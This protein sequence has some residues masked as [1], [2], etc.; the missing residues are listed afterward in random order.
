MKSVYL[1]LFLSSVHFSRSSELQALQL[2]YNVAGG[3]SWREESYWKG[4]SVCSFHGIKCSGGYVVSMNLSN[5]NLN[6]QL[7]DIFNDLS[8]LQTLDL[9]ENN[10]GSFYPDSLLTHRNIKYI[11]LHGSNLQA[12]I[13]KNMNLPQ[14]ET[15]ILSSNQ[16]QY[17][18]AI[19][20]DFS[21]MTS[22]TY[23]DLSNN[24]FTGNLLSL[25]KLPKLSTIKMS[26]NQFAGRFPSLSMS[27]LVQVDVS[28]NQ[29]YGPLPSMNG[30]VNL[31]SFDCSNNQLSGSLPLFS[32]S[33][34]LSHLDV[35]N[36]MIQYA[37]DLH[38]NVTLPYIIECHLGDSL[39]C[40]I[41]WVYRTKCS[42]ECSVS[43]D[44]DKRYLSYHME[45]SVDRFDEQSFLK[46][47]SLLGNIT[48]SRLSVN[49]IT[50]G[51]VIASVGLESGVAG[52]HD[53]QGSV[54]DTMSILKD[55]LTSS[56]YA[57]QGITLLSP[58]EED[59]ING[60]SSSPSPSPSPTSSTG[61]PDSSNTALIGGI[62]G[63]I[64][65]II[66]LSII[67]AVLAYRYH[68]KKTEAEDFTPLSTE[69]SSQRS[70]V[71]S[72]RI[73]SPKSSV[74]DRPFPTIRKF[75][76]SEPSIP[77]TTNSGPPARA[78]TTSEPPV[79]VATTSESP[80]RVATTSESPVRVANEAESP[81]R[82]ANEA[83]PPVRFDPTSLRAISRSV[84]DYTE[85]KDKKRIG[86]GAFGVVYRASWRDRP[87]AVKHIRAE[88]I[89]DK[90]MEDFVNEVRVIQGLRNHPNIVTFIDVDERRCFTAAGSTLA[91]HSGGSLQEYLQANECDLEDKIRFMKEIALGMLHLHKEKIIHRDLATRNVLLNHHLE[92]KV[93]ETLVIHAHLMEVADFGLSRVQENTSVSGM[94]QTTTGPIKW[95][96]PEAIRYLKYSTKSDVFSYGVVLWEIIEATDPWGEATAMD[97]AIRV[98]TKKERLPIPNE[99]P[100]TISN[101]MQSESLVLESVELTREGC[102]EEETSKR[103]NF[104]QI[105][106]IML[107]GFHSDR[108]SERGSEEEIEERMD[109][110]A[111]GVSG[112]EGAMGDRMVTLHSDDRTGSNEGSY[113]RA[114]GEERTARKKE[115]Y[116]DVILVNRKE[117]IEF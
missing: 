90:H 103:P 80:V 85:I 98:T 6:G 42:A 112:Y 105:V 92:A 67:I 25:S 35:S 7:V 72:E 117:V 69:V 114:S 32:D 58:V 23:L 11:N 96:A 56:D 61:S 66:L 82:V 12:F 21:S 87:V 38:R 86:S 106:G 16:L 76:T 101:L 64:L 70:E 39:R 15:L 30:A 89:T 33:T 116:V 41:G 51:S 1:L 28:N 54:Q 73:V 57:S 17:S 5:N 27:S 75:T 109:E 13:T 65:G 99:C 95:M 8:Y 62:V 45:G 78:A 37:V 31:V 102:W 93:R 83:E 91:H 36:N 81:V 100:P 43:G 59:F 55:Q 48:R 44:N 46:S 111:G 107:Q 53:N 4:I 47:L 19:T 104:E 71:S 68:R 29:L 24:Q 18:P 88:Y 2:F 63:G 52:K 14:I 40:P 10:L 50:S 22:L 84:I 97:V 110:H 49:K 113:E 79:R 20:P 74:A 26:N 77:R 9:S 3:G 34:N 108:E 115:S 60:V 94:T